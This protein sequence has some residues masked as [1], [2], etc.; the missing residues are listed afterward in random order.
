[1]TECDYNTV[2]GV[3][4]TSFSGN[5]L[6]DYDLKAMLAENEA[7]KKQMD[8]DEALQNYQGNLRPNYSGAN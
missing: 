1:M 2:F 8:I 3:Y 6:A 4:Y 5:D 7:L